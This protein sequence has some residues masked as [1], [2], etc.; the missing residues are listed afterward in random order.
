MNKKYLKR[1]FKDCKLL[2]FLYFT[3]AANIT[4]QIQK[5]STHNTYIYRYS[6]RYW[7]PIS[8]IGL[9]L[10]LIIIILKCCYVAVLEGIDEITSSKIYIASYI[11]NHEQE[12][13][14]SSNCKG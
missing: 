11:E 10:G 2:S 4:E 12:Q 13:K 7:H 8:I 5:C 9:L 3:G 14:E 1:L 6:I